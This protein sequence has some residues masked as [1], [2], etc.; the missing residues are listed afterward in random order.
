M[1][2]FFDWQPLFLESDNYTYKK[3]KISQKTPTGASTNPK[4]F[5]LK[6]NLNIVRNINGKVEME[7]L[8]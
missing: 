4:N 5:D 2:I 3:R 7:K 1:F 8:K 6:K